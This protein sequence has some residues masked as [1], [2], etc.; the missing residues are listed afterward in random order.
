MILNQIFLIKPE[1]KI[2]YL[3]KCTDS[4]FSV[5]CEAKEIIFSMYEDIYIDGFLLGVEQDW[6]EFVLV[7]SNQLLIDDGEIMDEIVLFL[8]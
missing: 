8:N 4:S 7:N 3:S 6:I 2:A 5:K 1:N